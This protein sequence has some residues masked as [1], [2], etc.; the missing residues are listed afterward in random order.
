MNFRQE[1]EN[2]NDLNI[3]NIWNN[4]GTMWK[5]FTVNGI[6]DINKIDNKIVKGIRDVQIEWK[7]ENLLLDLT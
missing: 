3:W 6:R 5:I 2:V 1:K 4:N 7:F